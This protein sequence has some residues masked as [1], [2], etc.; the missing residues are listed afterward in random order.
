MKVL[1]DFLGIYDI[2]LCNKLFNSQPRIKSGI[3]VKS[4]FTYK[5]L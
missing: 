3:V 1:F 2:S 4:T 5:E